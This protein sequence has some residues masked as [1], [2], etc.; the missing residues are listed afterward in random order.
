MRRAAK[1]DSVEKDIVEVLRAYGWSV[2]PLSMP[3][4]PDLLAG[5]Q[6]RLTVL[7]EVK[8][9]TQKLRPG[10]AAWIARW[11]GTPV[12]VM[13]SAKDAE[14]LA[15]LAAAKGLGLFQGKATA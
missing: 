13:Q 15:L 4:Y 6:G 8:T 12:Y 14:A 3:D 9:G 7:I 11:K 2:E 10:Q 1:R 5:Y